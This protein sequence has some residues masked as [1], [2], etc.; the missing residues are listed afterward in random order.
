MTH[1]PPILQ[2]V[3]A[4]IVVI[5]GISDFRWRRIPN[6]LALTGA[7]LGI[8]LNTFLYETSGLWMSLKGLGLAFLIYFPLYLLRAM[9]AGD[10]KLMGAAGAIIG[11]ANWFGLFV[12]TAILGG[13][14]AFIAVLWK[15]RLRQTFHN[16]WLILVQLIYRQAPYK[17][18]PELDVGNERAF[19][20]PHATVITFGTM[21]YL[22]ADAI[23]APR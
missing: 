10:V 7:V 4:V 8:G 23:W 2:T 3:L 14:V 9:G 12:I 22:I 21:I 16:I 20:L 6:W 17:A 11:P 15:G 19:R 18:S 1:L 13:A 5:G